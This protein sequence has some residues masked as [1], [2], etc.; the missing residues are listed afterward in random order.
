MQGFSFDSRTVCRLPWGLSV[1][2]QTATPCLPT[3]GT[4]RHISTSIPRL[5][6]ETSSSSPDLTVYSVERFTSK[7]K[8]APVRS[9]ENIASLKPRQ[10]IGFRC[11]QASCS[12]TRFRR[13]CPSNINGSINAFGWPGLFLKIKARRIET[14]FMFEHWNHQCYLCHPMHP[15]LYHRKLPQSL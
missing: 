14:G 2:C 1:D 15:C 5:P 7:F 12:E 8:Q 13:Q 3:R 9:T 11:A 6:G 10:N 4:D